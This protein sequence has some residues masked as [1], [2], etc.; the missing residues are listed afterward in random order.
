MNVHLVEEERSSE[1]QLERFEVSEVLIHHMWVQL[2]SH[3][4][5]SC[6]ISTQLAVQSANCRVRL[7]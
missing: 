4:S 3:G 6:H 7:S 2:D 1:R 5:T